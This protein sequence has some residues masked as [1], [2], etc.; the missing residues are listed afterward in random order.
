MLVARIEGAQRARGER[1]D[2]GLA[3]GDRVVDAGGPRGRRSLRLEPQIATTRTAD[4]LVTEVGPRLRS[5]SAGASVTRSRPGAD[6]GPSARTRCSRASASGCRS[7]Y[8]GGSAPR[9]LGSGDRGP[10][11]SV[12]GA[13]R[14][15]AFRLLEGRGGVGARW[16]V[17]RLA[18]CSRAWFLRRDQGNRHS[19]DAPRYL[20]L[21]DERQRGGSIHGG[22]MAF[23]H[24]D[25]RGPSSIRGTSHVSV[26]WRSNPRGGTIA[27][28]ESSCAECRIRDADGR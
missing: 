8:R 1:R 25:R 9:R 18:R 23:G 27:F 3:L 20:R 12:G 14:A 15:G 16:R 6:E 5:A 26:W 19:A 13:R 22:E 28:D 11:S 10:R 21:C 4:G 24:C 7:G 17:A 2:L